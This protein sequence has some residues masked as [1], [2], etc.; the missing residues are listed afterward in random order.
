MLHVDILDMALTPNNKQAN[1]DVATS[2]IA[3][4]IAVLIWAPQANLVTIAHTATS[5]VDTPLRS[6]AVA[7]HK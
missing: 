3:V 6:V 1:Q 7:E 2:G 4:V 5:Q